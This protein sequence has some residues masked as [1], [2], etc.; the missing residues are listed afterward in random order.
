[1]KNEKNKNKNLEH[2]KVLATIKWFKFSLMDQFS[3]QYSH[4]QEH[5]I[6]K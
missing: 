4:E 2:I 6:K 5:S 1:M 3:E